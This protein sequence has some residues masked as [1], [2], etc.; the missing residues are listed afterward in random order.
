M[1]CIAVINQKGGCGKT[2]V[3]INFAACLAAHNHSTL[4]VDM[5]S[6]GHCAVGLAV[7]EEQIERNIYDVLVSVRQDRQTKLKNVVWQIAQN[8]DLAPAGIELAALEPQLAGQDNTDECLK[9]L[10]A[11]EAQEYDFVVLDCPPSVGL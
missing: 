11:Q 8:F 2:T 10:L 7:P 5:D 3:S 4:L 1:H 6:Q 9:D